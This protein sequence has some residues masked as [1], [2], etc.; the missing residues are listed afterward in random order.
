MTA[1]PSL[2]A[3]RRR[4]H[5]TTVGRVAGLVVTLLILL[6]YVAPIAWMMITSFKPA[7]EIL[8]QTFD[9]MPSRL[10]FAAY[11]QIVTTGFL[12]Y[13]RNSFVVSS[14]ATVFTTVLALLAA[15]GFSRFKFRGSR[16]SMIAIVLSQ[17]VPFVVL[18]TPIYVIYVRLGLAN[19]SAGLIIAYTAVGLP[20]A[21]YMLLGYMNTVPISLDEAARIDGSGPLGT[22]F[23]VIM[24][25]SW[26]GVVTVAVYAFTRNWEEYLLATS[27]ISADELKTLPVGLAGLFGEF[28]TQWN[29]VMAAAT[30]STLPTMVVFLVLQRQ[31]IGNLTSGAVK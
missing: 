20:Y 16:V 14:A 26:P 27:L 19:T 30:V 11:V 5:L 9:V 29:L 24:P 25:V 23:R 15:Y 1:I 7:D 10:D 2:A 3:A 12:T 4:Q 18:V 6:V 31:L 22:L 8:S 13:I 17:L 21:I 28:T